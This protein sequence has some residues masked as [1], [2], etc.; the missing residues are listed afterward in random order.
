MV[1]HE[2]VLADVERMDD[3]QLKHS[4]AFDQVPEYNGLKRPKHHFLAHLALDVYRS[5]PPC[6]Y[7]CF[8]FE[9]FNKVIKAGSARTNWKNETLGIMRYWS[10]W[11]ACNMQRR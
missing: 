11:S 3:L 9:S 5:G 10:M 8:G 7:W 6:G 4:A 1:Q 2:L